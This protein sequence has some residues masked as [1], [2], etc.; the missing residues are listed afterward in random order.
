MKCFFVILVCWVV[1][2]AVVSADVIIDSL[3][4]TQ[5]EEKMQAGAY[6]DAA[7][8]YDKLILKGDSL[9]G[10]YA[11][12]MVE[13]L[14]K[15]YSIDELKLQ[16]N[17]HT[18]RLLQLT[19]GITSV[20]VVLSFILFFSMKRTGR[21]LFRSKIRLQYSKTLAEES[22]RNKSLFLS[23]M[24]HEIKTPLNALAGF[25]ELLAMPGIEDATRNQCNEII[26]MNSELLLKLV[27][28][29]VDISCLDIEN[30]AFKIEKSE[31][32]ALCRNVIKTLEKIKQ[33]QAA[34][35]FETDLPALEL[36]T[37]VSRL[38]QVMI[39]LLVNATKFTKEG[40][41]TLGL[42]L[43]EKGFAEFSV[44]DTGCGIPPEQ[45]KK[46]FGRFEK[47]NEGAQGTGLGLS[48]CELIIKRMG[49]DIWIDPEYE[50]G[51]RFVFTHPVKEEE[52]L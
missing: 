32:V 51:A 9:F 1:S 39:N 24:S 21:K 14:R 3:Y 17:I 44:T 46:V 33:T 41:I 34:V 52:M 4:W 16:E 8:L 38:Q 29:V 20:L 48:I 13:D 22:I 31:V 18:K 27:N 40:S 30:M 19:F 5:A 42:R 45:Q 11:D 50:N 36:D 35:F 2:S 43:N 37:D 12:E 7:D 25:S 28:D 10:A 23:N 49:G 26:R 47:L 6:E 15:K